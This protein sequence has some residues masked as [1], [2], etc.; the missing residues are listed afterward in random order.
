MEYGYEIM[1]T[2]GNKSFFVEG[3][4]YCS[5]S[6][7][8]QHESHCPCSQK[9]RVIEPFTNEE[10][11]KLIRG[12]VV[13]ARNY[14]FSDGQTIYDEGLLRFYKKKGYIQQQRG[15]MIIDYVE[16]LEFVDKDYGFK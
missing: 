3:C 15:Y 7:G 8:G 5:M 2:V 14:T 9:E 13:V 6:T 12:E 4:T 1:D 10:L 16:I 11:N